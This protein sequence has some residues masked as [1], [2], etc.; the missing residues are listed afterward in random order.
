MRFSSSLAASRAGVP[1]TVA[2]HESSQSYVPGSSGA[3]R[4]YS[5]PCRRISTVHD[6]GWLPPGSVSA[7]SPWPVQELV[8][9]IASSV[10]A[11]VSSAPQD[12]A[13]VA[14]NRNED[15]ACMPSCEVSP[16]D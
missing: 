6:G 7:C 9:F 1:L 8:P 4:L 10:H 13:A 15:V 12:D 11:L 3:T 2:T 14:Q 16:P 5:L